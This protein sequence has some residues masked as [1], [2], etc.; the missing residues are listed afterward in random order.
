MK[1]LRYGEKGKEKPGVLDAM[2]NIRDLSN[3]IS[4]I[5]GKNLLPEQI[6]K[7][8]KINI[9]KL[10]KINSDVRLGPCVGQIGKFI[11][12]GLNYS[13][14]A[15]E[16][17]ATIPKEPI[18]FSK[19]T[20]AI[21]GPNDDI[22]IPKNSKKTDWEVELG[23]IIGMGGKY[24]SKKEALNHVAGYCVINDVSEREYQLEH[25]G[26]WVKGKSC[27][28][29]G[30]IGPWLVTSDEVIDPQNLDLWLEVDEHLYQHSNTNKMVF[31][32]SNLVSYLSQFFTL[33]PGDVISTGTPPG[34]G[35]GIK[36][37]PIFLKPGQSIRLGIT[38]LG[39][40]RQ[41]TVAE[42]LL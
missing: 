29:F 24:I 31:T 4:D 30:P 40:Q 2:G 34:V 38:G 27:D 32:V 37:E 22:V 14:H 33:Y 7:L 26:Q 3:E 10:P 35:L 42:I 39:E 8:T 1:L 9:D 6:K 5:A 36:P 21:C 18:V 16:T 25:C 28:T 41:K 11:C 12:I 20:S 19:M 23:V 15:A 17:G 13:D